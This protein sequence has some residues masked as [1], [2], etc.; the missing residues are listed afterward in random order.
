MNTE[1]GIVNPDEGLTIGRARYRIGHP[2]A[3]SGSS[4]SDVFEAERNDGLPVVIKRL[5]PDAVKG[6]PEQ[7]PVDGRR[8]IQTEIDF[9]TGM[10]A[11]QNRHIVRIIDHGEMDG[12]PVVALER[13]HRDLKLELAGGDQDPGLERIL[14]WCRQV[15]QGLSSIHSRG[16]HHRDLKPSNILIDETGK[17]IKLADFGSVKREDAPGE[18]TCVGTLVY[19]AP[20]QVLPSRR[21]RD[22]RGRIRYC[23]D[24]DRHTDFFALGQLLFQLVTRKGRLASQS[25]IQALYQ[26]DHGE[27]ALWEQRDILGGIDEEECRLFETEALKKLE[28][29]ADLTLRPGQAQGRGVP[30]DLT[31]LLC[32]LLA[33]NKEDRPASA[34]EITLALAGLLKRLGCGP[35]ESGPA[36]TTMGVYKIPDGLRESRHMARAEKLFRPAPTVIAGM[37]LALGIGLYLGGGDEDPV[38]P[39]QTGDMP[40]VPNETLP[41]SDPGYGVQSSTMPPDAVEGPIAEAPADRPPGDPVNSTQVSE[42]PALEA[43][44]AADPFDQAPINARQ[45]AVETTASTGSTPEKPEPRVATGGPLVAGIPLNPGTETAAIT[46]P[47]NTVVPGKTKAERQPASRPLRRVLEKETRGDETGRS[48]RQLAAVV[49]HHPKETA[50]TILLPTSAAEAVAESVKKPQGDTSETIGPIDH[51]DNPDADMDTPEP[52]VALPEP[53]EPQ[54]VFVSGYPAPDMVRIDGGEF[55]MGRDHGSPDEGP[56]HPVNVA[57]FAV[58]RQEVSVREYL[59][60]CEATGRACDDIDGQALEMPVVRVNR[61]DAQTYTAWLSE[62]TGRAYRLLSEAEWEYLAR[63]GAGAGSGRSTTAARLPRA[64]EKLDA[65]LNGL[66][67]LLGNVWELVADCAHLNYRNAPSDGSAWKTGQ[68]GDC[69]RAVARGGSWFDPPSKA[70]PVNRL[71]VAATARLSHVGFR[72]AAT[73]GKIED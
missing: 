8:H 70:T 40:M 50:M 46:A 14:D 3:C 9:L 54:A 36:T 25:A 6:V 30:E 65:D 51:P 48:Q 55:T 21:E 67:G 11:D 7:Y 61:H 19:M 53:S 34:G 52:R 44:T 58:F 57:G 26:S 18:Y 73:V 24:T 28:D 10:N 35:V 13:M 59:R 5:R 62:E 31:A 2:L 49:A 33:R 27:Q 29:A 15:S 22:A 68:G 23:Y 63:S 37:A 16:Y 1:S 12:L 71:V 69:S 60:F 45:V 4:F 43:P 66:R 64:P 17:L 20:E 56:P 47:L 38:F 42:H 72:V 32:R 41:A 39:D